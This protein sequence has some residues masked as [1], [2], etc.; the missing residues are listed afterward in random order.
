MIFVMSMIMWVSDNMI[1]NEY[2]YS[3]QTIMLSNQSH[4]SQFK[5]R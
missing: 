4:T 5:T 1:M 2:K 3:E